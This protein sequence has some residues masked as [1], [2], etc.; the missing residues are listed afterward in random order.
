MA[1]RPSRSGWCVNTGV[2]LVAAAAYFIWKR[3]PGAA[4]I[5]LMICLAYAFAP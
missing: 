2:A 5:M 1:A 3:K 4:A